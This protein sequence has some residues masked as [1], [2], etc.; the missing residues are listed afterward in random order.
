[1]YSHRHSP[2]F[3]VRATF[4]AKTA[5]TRKDR[6]DF[7][8]HFAEALRSLREIPH[9]EPTK[10]PRRAGVSPQLNRLV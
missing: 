4:R 10:S 8:A 5:K 6:E 7:F 2:S 9:S 3:P 1:M